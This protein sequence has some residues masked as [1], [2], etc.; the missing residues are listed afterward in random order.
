VSAAPPAP[1]PAAG[2]PAPHTP[3]TPASDADARVRLRGVREALPPGER[4]LWQ[5]A[6]RRALLARHAFHVRL[7]GVYFALTT[8]GWAF[9]TAPALASWADALP[10]LGLQLLLGGVV[11]GLVQ[12]FALMTARGTAYVITSRRVVLRVGAVFPV[13]INVPLALVTSAGVH[14]F[15]DGSGQIVLALDP[16]VRVSWWLM[17]P[18]V[19]PTRLRWPEPLLRG[20][21]ADEAA[22]A[23]AALRE[24][25]ASLAPEEVAAATARAAAD[26][27]PAEPAPRAARRAAAGRPAGR[28]AASLARG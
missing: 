18:H 7:A 12:L 23:A 9:R 20:L 19:R 26:A 25:A 27:G 2:A 11:V 10:M 21:P 17:W 24:A 4:V 28:G 15:R 13:T 1:R 16:V 6:P 5:G 14:R 22:A 8:A 3:Y